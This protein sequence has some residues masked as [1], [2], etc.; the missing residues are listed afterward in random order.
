MTNAI[1]R[2]KITQLDS[3]MPIGNITPIGNNGYGRD[4][5][6]R[7]FRYMP[8]EH[9][10]AIRK[11]KL[12]GKD[13]RKFSFTHMQNIREITADLSNKYCG[14]ILLLQ[15]HIQF[16]TNV[17][18]ADN[19]KSRPL[20][21]NDL[22]KVWNVS[23]RTALTVVTELIERGVIIESGGAFKI[24]ER[25]H[26]RKKAGANVDVLIKTFFTALKRFRL[27]PADLGFVYKL[28]PNVHYETNVICADPFAENPTDIRFLNEKQI[29]DLVG[30]SESKTKETLARL[31][32]A[33]I[34]GEWRQGEDSRE[35]LT[36]LNPYVF[37]RKNGEPDKTL[38]ALFAAYRYEGE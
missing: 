35:K 17:L 13:T 24:N 14:Y 4:E 33:G 20:A 22:A 7:I 12:R 25:Y 5:V 19:G 11:R 9:I 21:V 2:K 3:P 16:R 34:V 29:G 15:P 38:Q 37:Y 30:M 8:I 18:I 10:E 26:F 36:V 6:G 32:K 27:T 23:K 28:L 31:R 1:L